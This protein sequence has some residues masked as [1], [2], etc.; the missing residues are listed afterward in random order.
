MFPQLERLGWQVGKI[1]IAIAMD[2]STLLEVL[3]IVPIFPLNPEIVSCFQ[4]C[5]VLCFCDTA[6]LSFR[7]GPTVSE[8][9]SSHDENLIDL[10][11]RRVTLEGNEK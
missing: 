10:E 11:V 3:L 5:F 8:V 9:I 1:E 2:T 7:Y 6:H 4:G